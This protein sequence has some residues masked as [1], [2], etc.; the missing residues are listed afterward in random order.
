MSLQVEKLEHNMAIL[1]VTM[2][3]DE[4]EAALNNSFR[5]NRNRFNVPGFRKGKATRAIVEKMYGPEVLYNDACDELIEKGLDR[6]L[7]ENKDL[8]VV[9][10]PEIDIT[11][12]E[13]GKDFIFTAKV[14]LKPEID[15]G[16]Y[17]GVKIEKVDTEV[18]DED[19]E[20]EIQAEL[21]R[22]ARMVP[23][24]DRPVKDKDITI[25]DFEGFVDGEAF[26]GG[27]GENYSLTIGSGS[28]IPGFEEQLI[29]AVVDEEK[30]INVT[31]PEDY[32]AEELKGKDAMFKVTVKEIKERELPELDDEFAGDVS[33][34]ET[35]DEYRASVRK[36][37][38]ESKAEKAKTEKENKVIE[39]IVK[40]SKMDI[41]DAMVEEQARRM[42]N[43][44]AQRL[45]QQGLTLDQYFM[46]TGLDQDKFV[47]QMKESALKRIQSS[48][49]IEA[50]V[51][52]EDFKVSD[53]DYEE[54][55]KKMAEDYKMELDKLKE[56]LG[57]GSREQI[58]KDIKMDKAVQFIV[59]NAKEK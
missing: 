59:D 18:S 13:K 51:K 14:A 34:Y 2:S 15:L 45:K 53:E 35:V 42:A 26:E 3:A 54:E 57:E 22:N 29:G 52:A 8:E 32:H 55:L 7:E 27:K 37:L 43:D 17:K 30:E 9:S 46:F 31:F 58:E 11:Q 25:I 47:D 56:L 48:L 10:R 41:P 23:A 28:F 40:D 50:V 5:K 44:Y 24:D 16:K 1:T 38:E 49:V 39:A 4:L 6:E 21:E 36:N 12:L 19:V 20:K 33:E